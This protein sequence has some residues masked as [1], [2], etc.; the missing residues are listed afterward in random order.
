MRIGTDLVEIKRIDRL[1]NDESFLMRVY[2]TAEREL[3]DRMGPKRRAEFLA[4]RFAVKESVAKAIGTGIGQGIKWK[5]IETLQQE[6]G[7]PITR[8]TGQAF[9]RMH[10]RGLSRVHVSISHAGGLALAFVVIT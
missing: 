7:E 5:D 2:T 3:A 4:G 9:A 1:M 10:E 6:N 8:I